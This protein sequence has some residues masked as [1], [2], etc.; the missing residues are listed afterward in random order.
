LA[1]APQNIDVLTQLGLLYEQTGHVDEAKKQYERIL[2]IVG[3]DKKLEKIK[4]VFKKFIE[5]L[6]DG[7]LNIKRKVVDMTKMDDSD[8]S[9]NEVDEEALVSEKGN[10]TEEDVSSEIQG[11]REDVIITVGVEGSINVRDEGSLSGIKLTKIEETG[12]FQKI[13][14]NEK[15]V[16]IL[17]P[18]DDGQESIKGWVHKKFITE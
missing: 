7:K 2:V 4:E 3:E 8:K 9:K 6:D 1:S 17:I 13:G 10:D 16:Q 11:S 14:E 5:N 12:K 15:W 18:T